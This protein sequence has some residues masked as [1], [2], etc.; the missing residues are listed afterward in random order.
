M[1]HIRINT[2]EISPWSALAPI[3]AYFTLDQH[4]IP[5]FHPNFIQ[6]LQ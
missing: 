5:C 6:Q 2:T 4:A 1:N 3:V